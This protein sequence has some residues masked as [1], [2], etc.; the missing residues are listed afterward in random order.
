MKARMNPHSIV[1]G[2]LALA[3]LSAHAQLA[4]PTTLDDTG[5][6][7][8]IDADRAFTTECTGTGQD[9][10]FGRDALH[11]DDANGHAGF[12][13]LKL[14]DRGQALPADAPAWRCVGDLVTGLVWEMKRTGGGLSDASRTYTNHGDGSKKDTSTL[15]AALNARGV[16]GATNWRLP[17]FEELQGLVDFSVASGPQVDTAWFP[18]TADNWYW[19]STGYAGDPRSAWSLQFDGAASDDGKSPRNSLLSVRLVHDSP[20]SLPPGDPATRYTYASDEVTD[21]WTHLVWKRCIAGLTFV[22]GYCGGSPL[23]SSAGWFEAIAAA[24]AEAAATGLAWRLP[25]AKELSSIMDRTVS[26]PAMDKTA[27]PDTYNETL[28][29][30][31][32]TAAS[33]PQA[34]TMSIC[35]GTLATNPIATNFQNNW[36]LVRDE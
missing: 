16:C 25:N 12:K 4:G 31:T 30:S 28:W 29:T 15:V 10:A 19:S 36:R 5:M 6:V 26:Y 3:A 34:R 21:T 24:N 8:C 14:D 13:Y 2:A 27:F 11:P 32:P 17:T 33:F 22:D 9:G 18:N 7:S 20:R 23:P 35:C 1:G